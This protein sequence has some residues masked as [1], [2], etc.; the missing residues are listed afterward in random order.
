MMLFTLPYNTIAAVPS[1]WPTAAQLR[2][3]L[4]APEACDCS[5][6]LRED[7]DALI[8]HLAARLDE[9]H[10]ADAVGHAAAAASDGLLEFLKLFRCFDVSE[11]CCQ[12]LPCCRNI[13]ESECQAT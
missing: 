10:A 5:T 2:A 9:A 11:S 12:V 1:V 4:E 6:E 7:N 3:A 8:V 13:T